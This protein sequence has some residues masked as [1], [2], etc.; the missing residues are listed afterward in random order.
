MMHLRINHALHVL[1]WML[2][3]ICKMQCMVGKMA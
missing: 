3:M 1:D 2:S